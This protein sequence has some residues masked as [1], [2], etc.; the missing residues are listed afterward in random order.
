MRTVLLAFILLSLAA[1]P[2]SEPTPINEQPMYGNLPKDAAMMKA[3]ERFIAGVLQMGY[4][5]EVESGHSIDSGW[6]SFNKGDHSTAMKRFNQAWLLD[7]ENGDAYYGFAL[8]T[9]VR[10]RDPDDIEKFF[11]IAFEKNNASVAA[12]VDFGRFL[13]TQERYD[14]SLENLHM[15]LQLEP[16]AFN[17]RARISFVQYKLGNFADACE[18]GKR[19]EENGDELE[20]GYLDDM[21]SR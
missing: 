13:W 4:T 7:P 9:A 1:C 2:T 5:R 3:D 10:D 8:I 12:H 21:C 16:S 11:Q 20:D 19:A 17:A 15:A 18:W 6:H 14:E